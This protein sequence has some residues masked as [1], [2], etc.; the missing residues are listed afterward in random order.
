M[1][2]D[3]IKAQMF[4]AMKAGAL[5]E[6]EILRVAVGEITTEQ[7][8]EGRKGNDEESQAI[9]RKL[10]KSNEESLAVSE[11]PAKRA[12]LEQEVQVLAAFLP[13]SLGV[14]EIVAA[15][16]PVV[17]AVRAA[18]NDGQ[19]TGVAMKHLKGLGA[20]VGGKDVAEAVKRL[21]A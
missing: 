13:K 10:I 2:L 1:L 7:A 12:V 16:A 8:R 3:E 11:D 17:E 20:P 9:L 4:K 15:L 19:A 21:R 5:V 6:K 14:D 18:G